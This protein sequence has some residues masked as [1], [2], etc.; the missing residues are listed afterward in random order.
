VRERCLF[1]DLFAEEEML[2][3]FC[4]LFQYIFRVCIGRS[5]EFTDYDR[6]FE[7]CF[8]F[9]ILQS[10]HCHEREQVEQR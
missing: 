1:R 8:S 3:L 2:G 9:V 10:E 4:R 5:F 7:Y 6:K